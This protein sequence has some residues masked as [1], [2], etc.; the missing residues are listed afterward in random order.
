MM[1]RK[2]NCCGSGGVGTNC[3][4]VIL[5]IFYQQNLL[6]HTPQDQ[7]TELESGHDDGAL[8]LRDVDGDGQSNDDVIPASPVD[9]QEDDMFG[10]PDVIVEESQVTP[11]ESL[12]DGQ[13]WWNTGSPAPTPTPPVANSQPCAIRA[14][15]PSNT[16]TLDYN[17]ESALASWNESQTPTVAPTKSLDD[18]EA[19]ISLLKMLHGI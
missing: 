16:E 19:R 17:P 11:H 13:G 1:R 8:L 3:L 5:F 9:F 2:I 15:D 6:S 18:I 14:A 10:S 7:A 4:V 12:E